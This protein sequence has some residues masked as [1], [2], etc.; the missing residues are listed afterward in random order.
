MAALSS[1]YFY[2]TGTVTV[3]ASGTT[4]TGSG[5][6]WV[7]MGVAAGDK[8]HIDG[9]EG[10][11]LEVLSE[12]SLTLILPWAG[13]AKAGAAY[14][15]MKDSPA[16]FEGSAAIDAMTR[17]IAAAR[18]IESGI[19]TIR[20]KS[21]SVNAPPGSPVTADAYIAGTA[22][23]GAWAGYAGY[24]MTWTGS[25][26]EPTAPVQ[27]M[28][29]YALDTGLSYQ[30]GAS[31]W[32]LYDVS[33][34]QPL[35]ATLT[36]LAGLATVA[37]RLPYFTATDQAALTPLTAAARGLL[38]DANVAAMR[39]T[40]EL[41]PVQATVLD[42]TADRLLRTGAFGLGGVAALLTSA[43]NLDT[44]PDVCSWYAWAAGSQPTGAPSSNGVLLHSVRSTG[45]AFQLYFSGEAM[46]SRRSS[47][48]VWQAWKTIFHTQNALGAVSMS[49]GIPGGG[50]IEFGSNPNGS[51]T[52]FL[53]GTQICVSPGLSVD[54][55]LNFDTYFY[56]P[57]ALTAWEYPAPFA[58]VPLVTPPITRVSL[59]GVVGYAGAVNASTAGAAAL[60]T[61]SRSGI[62]MF[63][64]AIG[65]WV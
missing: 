37:D 48:G 44:L 4:V 36:A 8:L 22:P 57:S 51:F 28:Q 29:A 17:V 9:A 43:D 32:A 3:A 19:N 34:R 35:D 54:S 7:T 38:D 60:C 13:G 27:G 11:I 50:M 31:A 12:T 63:M 41:L 30:R 52:R 46:L 1:V 64:S 62:T 6:S 58:A 56:V 40:L 61:R 53:D 26:W 25:G 39:T 42:A 47:G 49:G 55:T 33:G 14:V 5:T 21:Y 59:G 65:R 15:I 2:K 10:Y 18:L 23:T 45:I 24:L 20:V 16:R